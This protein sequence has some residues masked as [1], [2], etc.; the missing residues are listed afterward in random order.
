MLS[1][2]TPAKCKVLLKSN[3]KLSKRRKGT[4]AF[5]TKTTH[6]RNNAETPR[7]NFKKPLF[8]FILVIVRNTG[9]V[10]FSSVLTFTTCYGR[11]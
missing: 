7:N 9:R 3:I 2:K 5:Y 11:V 6:R 10:V 4:R 8:L 1:G